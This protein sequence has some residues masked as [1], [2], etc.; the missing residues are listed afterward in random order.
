MLN[1]LSWKARLRLV[2]AVCIVGLVALAWQNPMVRVAAQTLTRLTLM[3]G[4]GRAVPIP[5]YLLSANITTSTTTVVKATSGVLG[6]IIINTAGAAAHTITVY[7]TAGA[8]SYNKIATIDGTAAAGQELCYGVLAQ[9][10]LTVV[11]ATGTPANI[12]VTYR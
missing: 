10:G 8:T 9:D 3:G 1:R 6:C 12:T 7:G 11:T 2:T 4:T 5:A